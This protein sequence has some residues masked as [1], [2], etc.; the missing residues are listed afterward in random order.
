MK[1]EAIRE[2]IEKKNLKLA[3]R[4]GKEGIMPGK[5]LTKKQTEVIIANRDAFIAELKI[6]EEEKRAA[7]TERMAKAEAER[8]RMEEEYR[9]TADIRRFLVQWESEW[10]NV[11]C[12]LA[13]L[14]VKDGRAWSPE[15]GTLNRVDLKHVTPGMKKVAKGSTYFE[16]GIGGTAWEITPE[17]E[18]QLLAEQI[19]EAEE[20]ARKEAEE[21]AK[22]EA[23]EARKKA[24]KE[25]ALQEKFEEAKATGKP[26][27]IRSYTVPCEDPQEE[28]SMDIITE[29]AMPNGTTKT[30]QHHTW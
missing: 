30:E 5:K 24:E 14:V 23:E 19:P 1:K 22:K 3:T 2:M 12:Y 15:Y 25:A 18:E 28:C 10:G 29:Y 6:V 27:V 13:D 16:Y 11:E 26:V 20:A 21:A 4:N 8:K 9:K 17:Q 7:N